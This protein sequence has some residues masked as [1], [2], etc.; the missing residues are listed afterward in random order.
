FD[1]L[2]VTLY[3]PTRPHDTSAHPKHPLTEQYEARLWLPRPVSLIGTGYARIASVY[4]KPGQWLFSFGMWALAGRTT[5]PGFVDT[6]LLPVPEEKLLVDQSGGA[7]QKIG[8]VTGGTFD[9]NFSGVTLEHDVED[10]EEGEKEIGKGTLPCIIFSHGMEGMS[11]S[12]SNYLGSLASR[13]FVVAAIEHRDGSGPGSIVNLPGKQKRRVWHIKPEDLSPEME[14]EELKVA[15]LG[16]REA[17]IIET[18]RLFGRLNDGHGKVITNLKPHAKSSSLPSFHN[19]LD[20]SA[21]TMIGHSYGATGALQ[22]G[23]PSITKALPLNGVIALDPGKE[24]GPLNHDIDVPTLVFQSGEWTSKQ[25]EFYGQGWHF[26][27]VKKLVKGLDKGWFMTLLGTAHPSITDAPLIVPAITKLA[28]GTTLDP[29][30]A[31]KEYVDVTVRFLNFVRNGERK[32]ML[33]AEVTSPNGPFGEGGMEGI[34]AK[35]A[36]GREG[37]KWGVHVVPKVVVPHGEK[38][39]L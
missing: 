29:L 35:A 33:K 28:L 18:A 34:R 17:E 13:G 26:D 24:S 20:V 5:I 25:M 14:V 22:A 21:I 38:E 1:T 3:Y 36:A 39:K 10:D 32:G 4:F 30:V 2:A 31:L 8:T 16:F 19:R 27:V 23:K 7:K 37:G 11:Q 12:Y 6:P 15:Q 9:A